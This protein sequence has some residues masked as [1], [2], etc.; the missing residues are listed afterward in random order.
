M[1]RTSMGIVSALGLALGAASTAA[2]SEKP[3]ALVIA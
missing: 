3:V 1:R 2:A